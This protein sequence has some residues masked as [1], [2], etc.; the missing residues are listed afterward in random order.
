MI[1]ETE[2]TDPQRGPII[3]DYN[4][5]MPNE[6]A[7]NRCNGLSYAAPRQSYIPMRNSVTKDDRSLAHTVYGG[8]RN[9]MLIGSKAHR[10]GSVGIRYRNPKMYIKKSGDMT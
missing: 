8:K 7:G 1:L 9:H 6:A 10:P 5:N 4:E 3:I 2:V